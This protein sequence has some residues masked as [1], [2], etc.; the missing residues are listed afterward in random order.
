MPKLKTSSKAKLLNEL[1][2]VITALVEPEVISRKVNRRS[3]VVLA[4]HYD[5]IAKLAMRP[6]GIN[7][8]QLAKL[9]GYREAW[10]TMLNLKH[11]A[12]RARL[13]DHCF[14]Q[15]VETA[16][17]LRSQMYFWPG[18]LFSIT[19]ILTAKE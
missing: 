7:R 5:R 12:Q 6:N 4:R 17:S 8:K 2:R 18:F 15:H 19:N 13:P 10:P 11:A 1:F 9:P 14:R 3:S 16:L